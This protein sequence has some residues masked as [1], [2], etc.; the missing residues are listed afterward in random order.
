MMKVICVPVSVDAMKRLDYDLSI[1]GDLIE[2]NLTNELY[3][4][5]WKSG[6]FDEVNLSINKNIDDYEDEFID[7]KDELE[8]LLIIISR[9]LDKNIFFIELYELVKVAIKSSTG[10]FFFF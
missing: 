4:D 1:D 8:L 10:V 6:F 7:K 2:V 3:D 9:Y 5:I